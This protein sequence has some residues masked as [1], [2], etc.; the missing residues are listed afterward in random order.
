MKEV[1]KVFDEVLEKIIDEHINNPKDSEDNQKDFIDVM[2]S[3]MVDS[4]HKNIVEQEQ[5]YMIDRTSIKAIILDMIVAATDT[6]SVTAEWTLSELLRHPKVMKRL[7]EELMNK[8]GIDRQVEEND[9]VK[10]EYLD[11]MVKETM[12]LHPVAPFL[13]PHEPLEDIT[14][15]GYHI[16]K[17]SRVIINA[18]AIQR[19]PNVWSTYD[20]AEKFLKPPTREKELNRRCRSS[21]TCLRY[22]E[23]WPGLGSFTYIHVREYSLVSPYWRNVG[24][25]CTVELLA[26]AKVDSFK[27]MRREE[28]GLFVKSLKDE[29]GAV[30][31]V[32]SKVGSLIEDMTL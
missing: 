7:Q 23:Q 12:R 15:N 19:D 24:K 18:W 21:S 30:V 31:D 8:V 4:K 5:G 1:G 9:L 22:Q 6:T 11:M 26:A 10:L 14:I 20:D 25:M 16:P 2:L 17:K 29:S 32:S 13:L 28:V 27:N 3:L